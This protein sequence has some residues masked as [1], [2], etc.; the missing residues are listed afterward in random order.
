MP[1]IEARHESNHCSK[2][3]NQKVNI[4]MSRANSQQAWNDKSKHVNGDERGSQDAL[5][6][7]HSQLFTVVGLIVEPITS[8][9]KKRFS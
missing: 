1:C 8:I 2:I 6:S 9:E 4:V 3:P 5:Q 7:S